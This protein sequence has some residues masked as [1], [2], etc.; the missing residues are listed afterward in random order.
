MVPQEHLFAKDSDGNI[1]NINDVTEKDR[2]K[3]FFC[4]GCDNE[5]RPVIKGKKQH[6]FR[7]KANVICNHETYLH[8]LGKGFIKW[9]FNNHDSFPIS[10]YVNYFC[11]KTTNCKFADFINSCN[12]REPYSVDLKKYYDTCEEEVSY[13]GF[14][15]D[16]MLSSSEHPD[17]RPIFIEISVSHDCE[18]EKINSGIPIIEIKLQSEYDVFRSF[19]SFRSLNEENLFIDT[20]QEIDTKHPYKADLLPSL[21]FYNFKRRIQSSHNL[22]RFWIPETPNHI[23]Y[24]WVEQKYI[25]CIKYNNNHRK[26]SI[27]ELTVL[28]NIQNNGKEVNLYELGM[29]KAA[30]RGLN[31]RHCLMC[32]NQHKCSIRPLFRELT[33]LQFIDIANKCRF[34]CLDRYYYMNRVLHKYKSLPIYE[35]LQTD[36]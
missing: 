27:Y 19:R 26:D 16:L 17:R 8:R 34:F 31:I 1:I 36:S 3:H 30:D 9:M 12:R 7:H 23:L 11:D 10:Y 4:I 33:Y 29:V 13:R 18:P 32:Y 22:D 14:R 24:G 20:T 6:H 5:M 21:R 35:W 25:D 15:A 28:S 2:A